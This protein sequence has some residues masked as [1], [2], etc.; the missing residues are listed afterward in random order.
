[1]HVVELQE[2]AAAERVLAGWRDTDGPLVLQVNKGLVDLSPLT[3]TSCVCVGAT[4]TTATDG[5]GC[6]KSSF[7]QLE[8]KINGPCNIQAKPQN[9]VIT[10]RMQLTPAVLVDDVSMPL[11]SNAGDLDFELLSQCRRPLVGRPLH[12]ARSR[13]LTCAS[14]GSH[15]PSLGAVVE[16]VSRSRLRAPVTAGWEPTGITCVRGLLRAD[17]QKTL[18]RAWHSPQML[19]TVQGCYE[20][21]CAKAAAAWFARLTADSRALRGFPRVRP[22]ERW[23]TAPQLPS[24]V[25]SACAPAAPMVL[26][27]QGPQCPLPDAAVAAGQVPFSQPDDGE[28]VCAWADSAAGKMLHLLGAKEIDAAWAVA[29]ESSA[30]ELVL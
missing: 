17:P 23:W 24:E 1:M 16:A 2:A 22:T 14:S 29:D 28:I 12:A 8:E 11:T 6:L 21:A 13:L 5:Q 20:V 19:G 25:L 7:E 3:L 26:P 30:V 10:R 9:L 18:S 4:A 27:E 15:R